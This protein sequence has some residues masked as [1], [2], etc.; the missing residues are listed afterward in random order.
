MTYSKYLEWC[1]CSATN[2]VLTHTIK[3]KDGIK[4]RQSVL[5]ISIVALKSRLSS[6]EC[7]QIRSR[8][9]FSGVVTFAC[10]LAAVF[11]E[12]PFGHMDAAELL[13]TAAIRPRFSRSTRKTGQIFSPKKGPR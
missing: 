8:G 1:A 7:V 3:V 4:G 5:M 11:L 6:S 12:M 13:K 9:P 2:T 10:S